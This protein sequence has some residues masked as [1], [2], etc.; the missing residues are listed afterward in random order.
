MPQCGGIFLDIGAVVDSEAA[1]PQQRDINGD[2]LRQSVGLEVRWNS[3]M[4]PIR[5][6]YGWKIDPREGE[7]PGRWEF[8]MGAAF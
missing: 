3:P 4:G 6:A 1:D 7:D 2:T 5:L 8:A